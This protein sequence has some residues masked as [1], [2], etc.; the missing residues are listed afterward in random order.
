MQQYKVKF[1]TVLDHWQD[2]RYSSM[3]VNA[4]SAL[5]AEIKVKDALNFSGLR[6]DQQLYNI[7]VK[8]I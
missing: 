8:V 2:K 3:I 7:D 5:D 4:V 6:M 1:K